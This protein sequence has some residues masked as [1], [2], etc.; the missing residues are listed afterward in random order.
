MALDAMKNGKH[1]ASEVPVCT[2]CRVLGIVDTS[3]A[4]RKHCMILENCCYGDIEM[5]VRYGAR[6]ALSAKFTH[7]EA[8]YSTTCAAS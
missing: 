7:G 2:R 4:T 6:R 5:M 1:A 8:A 3:E